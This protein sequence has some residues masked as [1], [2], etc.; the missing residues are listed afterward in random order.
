MC[1]AKTYDKLL[2]TT[3]DIVVEFS[4]NGRLAMLKH[5]KRGEKYNSWYIYNVETMANGNL[6]LT[7]LGE[8]KDDLRNPFLELTPPTDIV[9]SGMETENPQ[10]SGKFNSPLEATPWVGGFNHQQWEIAYSLADYKENMEQYSPDSVA[11]LKNNAYALVCSWKELANGRNHIAREVK[12]TRE[13]EIVANNTKWCIL[14]LIPFI[15][16]I[17]IYQIQLHKSVSIYLPSLKWTA[18]NQI[19]GIALSAISISFIYSHWWA[20]VVAV[21]SMSGIQITNLFSFLHLRSS[22]KYKLN[23]KIPLLPAIA[24]GYVSM[25]GSYAVISAIAFICIPGVHVEASNGDMAIGLLLG[26]LFIIAV[27][28][29]Y[30]RQLE[31]NAP[32][33]KG[34]FISIAIITM[35]AAVAIL[36]LIIVVIAWFIFKGIGKMSLDASSSTPDVGLK[37][38]DSTAESCVMCGRLGDYSCPHFKENGTPNQTCSS[39]LPR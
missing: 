22:I 33:L 23:G 21:I 7:G 27:G 25:I 16:G 26:L 17:V 34:H 4:N 5:V 20:I 39:W 14:V 29:W 12:Q 24:F 38:A 35:F 19:L 2:V 18:F 11:N 32:E 31:K 30:K 37:P 6:H 13:N 10:M 1:H 8:V 15:L 36:S 3:N 28:L 9:I